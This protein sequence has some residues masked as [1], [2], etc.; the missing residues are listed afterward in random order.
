MLART[1]GTPRALAHGFA[2]FAQRPLRTKRRLTGRYV[3]RSGKKNAIAASL[4]SK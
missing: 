1:F 3:L 4:G 2:S